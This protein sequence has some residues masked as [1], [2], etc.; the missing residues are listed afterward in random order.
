MSLG[1]ILVE[2]VK[3]GILGVAVCLMFLAYLA[4]Q[5]MFTIRPA[6]STEKLRIFSRSVTLFM[7]AS[8]V[9]L[10]LGI[11]AGFLQP[12]T[13]KLVFDIS[14]SYY[15]KERHGLV[16]VNF[17]NKKLPLET[18]IQETFETDSRVTIEVSDV[19]LRLDNLGKEIESMKKELAGTRNHAG[20]LTRSFVRQSATDFLIQKESGID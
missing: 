15:S 10:I 13:A 18:L 16:A 14:P 19:I 6:P 3:A 9:V 7:S 12:T 2:L 5:R 11:V 1:E 17:A 8:I 20:E 4:L